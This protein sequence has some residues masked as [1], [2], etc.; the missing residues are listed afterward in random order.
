MWALAGM[1]IKAVIAPSFGDIFYGNCFQ[2]GL[3]PVA[4]PLAEVEELAEE[5]RASPG[6]ARVTIDLGTRG[7]VA[8]R[9]RHSLRVDPRA[10]A[11]LKGSTTSA[12]RC[13]TRT[14]CG[15]AGDGQ[16]RTAVGL[17]VTA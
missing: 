5:M 15:L 11:L 4:L 8:D 2:N 16:R 12:R 9:P 13:P 3:L 7:R 14:S 1:G 17:A 10:A 6:N